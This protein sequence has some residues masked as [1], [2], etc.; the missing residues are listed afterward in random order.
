MLDLVLLLEILSPVGLDVLILLGDLTERDEA[1]VR[2]EFDLVLAGCRDLEA[3]EDLEACRLWEL[4]P[5]DLLLLLDLSAANAGPIISIRA[6]NT[7]AK[8]FLTFFWYFPVAIICLLSAHN[9]ITYTFETF[10]L[11]IKGNNP[12]SGNKNSA[13]FRNYFRIITIAFTFFY[14]SYTGVEAPLAP[15]IDRKYD[16][17]GRFNPGTPG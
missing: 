10:S 1:I 7:A 3:E 5:L 11:P 2:A 16:I 15:T 14:W 13:V 6:K 17:I 8:A 12:V 4:P 9:V